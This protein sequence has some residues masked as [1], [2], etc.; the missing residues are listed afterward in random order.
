M[1]REEQ[2][3]KFLYFVNSNYEKYKK[4][5]AKY[6]FD[7]NIVFDEDVF[8]D[9]I[10]KVYDF[11]MKNGINDD[12]EEGLANYW[13]KSFQTN[14]KREKLYSRNASRDLNVD[15]TAELDLRPNGDRELEKKLMMETYSDFSVIYMLEKV[16]QNFDM[17][18]FYCFRLYYLLNKMTYSKLKD[19]TKVKDCKKRVV[20]AKKWLEENITKEELDRAFEKWYNK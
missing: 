11:I 12:S 13:F 4:K 15:A 17:L 7:R 14:T 1:Q 8:S 3:R 2:A 19:I 10:L 5:W 16:E 9:T 20:T 18:T 6:L